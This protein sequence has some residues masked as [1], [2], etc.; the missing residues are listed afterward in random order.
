[1]EVTTNSAAVHF[2]TDPGS[3][4]RYRRTRTATAPTAAH[5]M[6]ICAALNTALPSGW[7]GTMLRAHVAT[8]VS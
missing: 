1:M 7:P 6:R 2:G 5:T 4:R 8:V 3:P